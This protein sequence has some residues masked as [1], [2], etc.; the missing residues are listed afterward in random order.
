LGVGE[1]WFEEHFRHLADVTTVTSRSLADRA[2]SLGVSRESVIKIPNGADVGLFQGRDV[3]ADRKRL[4]LPVNNLLLGY[5][6]RDV[7]FD[8]PLILEATMRVRERFPEVQLVVA[9]NRPPGYDSLIEKFGA[10]EA[11]LH[12]GLRDYSDIPAIL[13]AV[14]IGLMPFS[15]C[16]TNLG[17]WPAKLA[18]YLAAGLPV[19]AHSV[20]EVGDFLREESVG[21]LA[22]ESASDFAEKICTLA[23][24]ELLRQKMGIAASASATRR[25]SW[26]R[27]GDLIE[28][29]YA[30]ALG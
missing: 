4:S 1:T 30:K 12:L 17:A 28:A 7:N 3:T 9:G 5:I 24:D 16:P 21:L 13:S 26:F 22:E 27:I 20:G 6:G 25:L 19:V 15:H 14:D 8:L 2:V 11:V 18:D 10:K 29:A 23:K